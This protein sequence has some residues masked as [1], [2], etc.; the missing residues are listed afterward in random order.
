MPGAS[1]EKLRELAATPIK[2]ANTR[3]FAAEAAKVWN[4]DPEVAHKIE[5]GYTTRLL[6]HISS[7]KCASRTAQACCDVMAALRVNPSLKRWVA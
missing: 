3:A 4:N 2:A 1:F 5:H 7:G 6:Q